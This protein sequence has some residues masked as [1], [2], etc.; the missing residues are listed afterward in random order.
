MNDRNESLRTLTRRH[1][2][3]RVGLRHRRHGALS[4]LDERLFAAD[5]GAEAAVTRCSPG[6]RTSRPRPRTSSTSSWPAPRRRSTSST[7]SRSSGN[8]TA[9]P[10][11]RSSSKGER[12][13]F[14]EGTPKLLGSPYSFEVR[15]VRGRDL[16]PA[17]AHSRASSTTSPSCARCTPRSSTTRPAQIFM[18][19]GHQIVGR[20]S[21]GSWV[22]Y[23]LGTESKD[24]PGF[25]VLLSGENAARR[26]QSRAGEAAS[27]PPSTRASSSA[28]RAIPSCS[29]PTLQA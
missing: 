10:S 7:T 1:F 25:V 2:F 24:L 17:A 3:R 22:T 14:I 6:P 12:F 18:N 29:S 27:C 11:R 16:G 8:T 19:T 4:L 26:R 23:G 28:P 21:M 9:S 5:A 15:P 13:A 20:P